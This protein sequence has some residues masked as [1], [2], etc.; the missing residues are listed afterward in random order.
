L[1]RLPYQGRSIN[2]SKGGCF[3]YSKNC[4]KK[5]SIEKKL[6]FWQQ[7]KLLVSIE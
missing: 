2:F 7:N 3:K 6:N 5:W 1:L 4:Y